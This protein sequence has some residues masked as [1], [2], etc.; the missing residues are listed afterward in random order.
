MPSLVPGNLA[1]M[2]FI[3]NGPR[4]VCCVNLSCSTSTPFRWSRM[5]CSTL[6]WAGLLSHRGP[7]ATICRVYCTACSPLI[8]PKG[9]T[10]VELEVTG[11][12]CTVASPEAAW[13]GC[14]AAALGFE[15]AREHELNS[16]H[17]S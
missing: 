10:F 1:M 13:G 9:C 7:K 16:R 14:G 11:C 4:L 17:A 5:Y 2:L 8:L 6:W 12:C 3:G 15:L